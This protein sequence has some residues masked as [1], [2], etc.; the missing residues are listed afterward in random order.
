MTEKIRNTINRFA[1]EYVFTSSDFQIEASKQTTVNR[2]LNNMVAARQIRRL[3]KGRFYKPQMSEF[4]ELQPDSFQL[5]KDLIE[6]N[7][8]PIGYITNYTILK[9]YTITT[10]ATSA[11]QII[12]Q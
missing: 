4:G 9:K 11:L 7:G 6:K 3:S 10:Q 8:K 2:I 1:V 12:Y 5:V